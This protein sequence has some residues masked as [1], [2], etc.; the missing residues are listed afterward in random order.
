MFKFDVNNKVELPTFILR[1][2]S[3][4]NLGS[5]KGVQ[6]F[7][8]TFN[9][10]SCQEFSC[11][12]YKFENGVENPL[13]NK[14]KDNKIIYIPELQ[15]QY[16]IGVSIDDEDA[17]KK[18]ITGKSLCEAE[19]SQ[20][21]LRDIE[22][23][24]E[25]DISRDDYSISVFYD[26][27]NAKTS[28]LNR[29]LDKVPHYKIGYV[30]PTL[31]GISR[32]FNIDGTS[33]YDFMTGDL[34]E[35]YDCLFVFD[36]L[37]RTINCYD[38]LNYCPSCKKRFDSS[39][40]HY[41]M[42]CP[43]CNNADNI[44]KGYGDDTTVFISKE[45]LA[46]SINLQTNKDEVKNM[47]KII[48][49]DDD[50]TAA[51]SYLTMNNGYIINITE[52]MKSDMS[53]TLAKKV[54]EYNKKLKEVEPEYEA[55][56]SQYYTSL[57]RQL[58]LEH[59][60]SPTVDIKND[61]TAQ[62]ELDKIQIT[63]VSFP[64]QT[65]I[66]TIGVQFVNN[67]IKPL[68]RLFV[69]TG[70]FRVSI[71]D[72]AKYTSPTWRGTIKVTDINSNE[73]KSKTI[74][75]TVD[76][77][78]EKY[79]KEKI[80][81][82][83]GKSELKDIEYDWTKYSLER[84]NS[85]QSAYQDVVDILVTMKDESLNNQT[86]DIFDK[87]YQKYYDKLIAIQKQ[88]VVREKEIDDI[89]KEINNTLALMTEKQKLVDM[90]TFFGSNYVELCTYLREDT[91]SN[92]NYISDGLSDTEVINRAKELIEAAKKE[93]SKQ[94]EISYTLSADINN[95]MVMKEFEPLWSRFKLG[96][97]LRLEA[98]E[99]IYRLRL[100]SY[101]FDFSDLSKINVE[102]SNLSKVD[103]IT[104]DTQSI[105]EQASSL[106][107]T[108]SYIQQQ[109]QKNNATSLILDNWTQQ[110]F[111][112]T[113]GMVSD[114]N[115]QSIVMDSH[116]LLAQRW[117]E[118]QNDY[119]SRKIKIIN[120]GVYL[121]TDNF[122]TMKCGIGEF[123]Y[124]DPITKQKVQS[125]GLI[126]D[127][128][129]GKIILGEKVGIYNAN[130]SMSFDEN[131]LVITTNG[132]DDKQTNAFTIQKQTI[133]DDTVVTKKMMYIDENGNLCMG[134]GT[135]ISWGEVNSPNISDITGLTEELGDVN[136]TLDAM[137]DSYT[138]VPSEKLDMKN[139]WGK[140]QAEYPKNIELADAFGLSKD[141]VINSYTTAYNALKNE[142][143]NCGL[144]KLNEN[145][146]LSTLD[147]YTRLNDY[148]SKNVDLAAKINTKSKELADTASKN[149]NDFVSI[150]YAEDLKDIN[151]QIDAKSD[152]YYQDTQPH[153]EY[154]NIPNN[155]N[156]NLFVGD[157]WYDTTSNSKKT[158]VYTKQKKD[159]NYDYVWREMEVPSDIFDLIDGKACI[160]V[161]KP[162]KYDVGDLIIPATTFVVD[163]VT[164]SASKV[165]KATT[166]SNTIFKVS[167]WKEINYTDDSKWIA[168]TSDS[169][170]FGKYKTDIQNQ[171][172]GKANCTYGGST[173]P[174]NPE[175]G[176]L[177]FCTANSKTYDANKAYMYD[178]SKWQEANGVPD[179]VWDIADGKSSI[180]VVK[181]N[182]AIS[183]LDNNFYHK[184][185]IW[186]LEDS[187]T[188]NEKYYSK[189]SILT[190]TSD[191]KSFVESHWVEKV[192]YT[193][194]T[195]ANL[196]ISDSV[197]TPAEKRELFVIK[198]NIEQEYE[199]YSTIAK[200][201]NLTYTDYT[202]AYDNLINFLNSTVL[203]NTSN[204]TTLTQSQVSEYKKHFNSY[205]SQHSII[206][207]NIQNKTNSNVDDAHQAA[208]KADK[209][210]QESLDSISEMSADNKITP[211]EKI[212]LREK[213]QQE[214]QN[215][216]TIVTAY[217]DATYLDRSN[218]KS[219]T[220][221][222]NE[223][224]QYKNYTSYYSNIK[225]MCQVILNDMTST[226]NMPD[227]GNYSRTTYN[228][229]WK[230][231]YNSYQTLLNF[232]NQVF[233][234]TATRAEIEG[235][236]LI[237]RLG[238]DG[239]S[240][241][242]T[243]INSP[244]IEG[245]KLFIGNRDNI[246]AEITKDGKLIARACEIR[247]QST[248]AGFTF[249]KYKKYDN[250]EKKEI[251]II[252]LENNTSQEIANVGIH[253]SG[254]WA[255]FAGARSIF[256]ENPNSL[257]NIRGEYHLPHQ[258][259]VGHEG[260][261]Y[262]TNLMIGNR[263]PVFNANGTL[264]VEATSKN[265]W[266]GGNLSVRGNGVF[267]KGVII[268]NNTNSG[269]LNLIG[270][271][272][273]GNKNKP[274]TITAIATV[275]IG[276]EEKYSNVNIIGNVTIGN[277]SLT[278]KPIINMFGSCNISNGLTV[279]G[280][281]TAFK[282][283][284]HIGTDENEKTRKQL[285]VNGYCKVS[286]NLDIG[287]NLSIN[288]GHVAIKGSSAGKLA[289]LGYKTPDTW[290]WINTGLVNND[291]EQ[292]IVI[293]GNL[294]VD[295]GLYITGNAKARLVKTEHFGNVTMS[296]Y[297]TTTPYFGDI[298]S[299]ETDEF[300]KCYIYLDEIFKETIIE[301]TEYYIFLQVYG[302]NNVYVSEKYEDYFVIKSNSPS[303]K[304]DWEIKCRQKDT[305]NM[306][307]DVIDIETEE[308]N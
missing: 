31:R 208:N 168:W 90:K 230:K 141:S 239:T 249:V 209:K 40:S 116:G 188:L 200:S 235:L 133:V 56:T 183:S 253:S 255:M 126:A 171:F 149:L 189:G 36:S 216:T 159:S 280:D 153:P 86:E 226:Y 231:Y 292:A 197:L 234:S 214:E 210:A 291:M 20:R 265:S 75:V 227:T 279:A 174:D 27:T 43:K 275:N 166:N 122:E 273:I 55:L 101:S 218:S 79:V 152:V 156:Y 257:E 207:E 202:T 173:P 270:E 113:L 282:T 250:S 41:K 18:T 296:A 14:I 4:H 62:K 242:E 25:S 68:A 24:T 151:K 63:T 103:G 306:R 37:T 10:N 229:H 50:I 243:H 161:S 212:Q 34:A 284:V 185:D 71:D 237:E 105:L 193:D 238:Y 120:N 102:F 134:N 22:I 30:A 83:L 54:D 180:F 99:K 87:F 85:F 33:I 204:S 60:M 245:G 252:G 240:I 294:R 222:I 125:Y 77:D 272:Y 221:N 106:S 308:D 217:K 84:L 82:T 123:Y 228:T 303:V 181:P 167:D 194:D 35:E 150:D 176:D 147:I 290:V 261:V 170:E 95:L 232:L 6:A 127:T 129:I 28:I 179:N 177:W 78:Y 271:C 298:G 48:G 256:T 254:G 13:W 248:I 225:T 124:T 136:E 288:S 258:F 236:E 132:S 199:K 32:A 81:K 69:D 278:T 307:M 144:N 139:E 104:T 264:N 47:L 57:T 108:I 213:Y 187:M 17:T 15:E 162:N 91:Y 201:L 276:E 45:N 281:T 128:I 130:N 8:P 111:I 138:L 283:N 198:D 117:D 1:N 135:S 165:Y 42:I 59:S 12:V 244:V 80:K 140:I 192:R 52:D 289:I 269:S 5:I 215:Y 223:S 203:V 206:I 72:G 268:G 92:D 39:E 186:I 260:N 115:N 74:S 142:I 61:S 302:N 109:S 137:N 247:E 49:G 26:E 38:L 219:T 172:D 94:S 53:T 304:F 184:N 2:K 98:D 29:I 251:E 293:S 195:T 241:N 155:E 285:H 164:F 154:K 233:A 266:T 66:K 58:E 182:K 287:G 246:F 295:G 51:V 65:N 107:T 89:K 97:W 76:N 23:N 119:D 286:Q 9:F 7:N 146:K 163:N 259:S 121:T 211:V 169:G 100:I 305:D 220:L 299:G 67:A 88:I 300:C 224:Q 46:N 262:C 263:T 145:T 191:S 44:I 131:G 143:P 178:G 148:Y 64:P 110:G 112:D 114:A 70:H 96:N 73:D 277:S 160:Y 118:F 19:L 93:C 11:E 190:A 274:G 297:E 157:L 21:I 175:K 158:Y 196:A 16:E 3:L 301:N 205:Y 267:Y